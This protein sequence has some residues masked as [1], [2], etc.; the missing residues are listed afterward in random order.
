M[1]KRLSFPTRSFGSDAGLPDA[2]SL[3]GWVS[4]R[5]GREGDLTSFLLEQE[6]SVQQT[7]GVNLPCAG[8]KFYFERWQDALTGIDGSRVTGE[9]GY[10]PAL[11][12]RDAEEVSAMV[13]GVWMTIPAPHLL[14]L[15]DHYYADADEY[16]LAIHTM[17]QHMMRSGRDAHLAGHVLFCEQILQEE[18]EALAGKKTL[19]FSPDMNRKSLSRCLEYQQIV[20]VRAG[21][22]PV[23]QELMDEY[24]VFR[25][26]LLDPDEDDLRQA[27]TMRD[28][29]QITCG[30]YCPGECREYWKDLVKKSS[31][32]K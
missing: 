20:A 28:P 16:S 8:G 6:L 14:T 22:L 32:L 13:R 5:R 24:E 7:A 15:K 1:G 11:I 18:L 27:L 10:D 21:M 25:I 26:I 29:D 3:S 31:I 23:L 19:F 30:G 9:L 12:V 17:Y 2:A 4:A